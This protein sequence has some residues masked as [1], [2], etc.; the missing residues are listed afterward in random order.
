MRFTVCSRGQ[1]VG[2][3]D[4]AIRP[5]EE[6]LRSGWFHPNAAGEQLMSV[7]TAVS[8]ALRALHDHRCD[9]DFSLGE[10]GIAP[11]DRGAELQADVAESLHHLAALDL[12]LRRADGSLVPTLDVS[13]QDTRALLEMAMLEVAREEAAT[14]PDWDDDAPGLDDLDAELDPIAAGDDLDALLELDLP[15]HGV[16]GAPGAEAA[17]PVDEPRDEELDGLRY[18][19]HVRLVPG[20][21]I[22]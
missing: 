8:V 19:L 17:A 18:Q 7:L 15:L 5:F 2:E 22:G 21:S 3:S 10:P 9:P 16:P 20:E 11:A 6:D 12:E 4:L 14:A 1:P 13:I